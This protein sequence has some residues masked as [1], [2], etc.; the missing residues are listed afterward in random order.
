M[1]IIDY[2][3]IGVA[4][5][6]L[7]IGLVKGVLSMIIDLAGLILGLF[8][9][10][11]FATLV[12]SWMTTLIADES[13]R[14]LVAYIVC[15]LATVMVVAIVGKL[16]KKLITKIS[17]LKVVDKLLGAAVSLAIV[18]AVFGLIF[19][20]LAIDTDNQMISALLGAIEGIVPADSFALT[21]YGETNTVG[22][23]LLSLIAIG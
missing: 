20:L 19:A 9:A 4:V 8:V 7:I 23:W 21:L 22:N 14:Y 5:I 3:F 13:T 16:I 1:G 10:G 18:Y 11:Q 12:S 15:L 2:I 17:V 6:A